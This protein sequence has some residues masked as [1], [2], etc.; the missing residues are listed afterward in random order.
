M[1]DL[2]RWQVAQ[3][4]E[5]G[6]WAQ[7]A[8]R[9]ES[10]AGPQLDWYGW[11]ARQLDAWLSRFLN[12]QS[13]TQARILEI[14]SGPLGIVSALP[15]GER[16]GLDPLEEFYRR[17]ATLTS[18]RTSEVTYLKG[19][20]EDLPFEDGSFAVVIIDNVIDHTRAPGAILR[21][22]HRVLHE[23]GLLYLAVNIHTRWGAALH[24]L[25]AAVRAD[26][27]H[28]HTYARASIERLLTEGHFT[29]CEAQADSYAVARQ[30]DRQAPQLRARLKA[31]AGVTEFEFR[32]VAR[33][34]PVGAAAG[35]PAG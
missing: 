35:C 7:L 24:A 34:A 1:I 6:F 12:G 4:H 9:I 30:R 13:R 5:R 3:H 32:A 22:I 19:V 27:K 21:E 20:G 16:F 15:W 18:L 33:K 11:K 26:P 17:D 23:R 29:I 25:L 14:G 8:R 2:K 31:Y 28:P 10:G